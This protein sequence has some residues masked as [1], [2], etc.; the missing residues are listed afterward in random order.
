MNACLSR[1]SVPEEADG[2]KQRSGYHERYAK[3]WL[4]DAVVA[5]LEAAVN[6]VVERGACLGSNEEA[7]RHG[8]E[9]EGPDAG[10]LAVADLPQHRKCREHQV[11]E[12]I[13]VGHVTGQGNDDGLRGQHLEGP[14]HGYLQDLEECFFGAVVFSVQGHVSRLFTQAVALPG[15]EFGSIGLLQPEYADDLYYGSENGGGPE[16]PSPGRIL[17]DETAGTGADGRAEEWRETVNRNGFSTLI[18]GETITKEPLM[19]LVGAF[20][21]EEM[22]RS[23]HHRWLMAHFHQ[24][25]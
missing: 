25:H 24:G 15:E 20:R 18:G 19:L 21:V 12:P 10:R 1:P 22:N 14:F 4:S 13:Q 8:D 3:L 7:R 23:L 9:M 2:D 17:R 16:A 5:G 11:H 6:P